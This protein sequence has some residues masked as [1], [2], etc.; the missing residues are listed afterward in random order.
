MVTAAPLWTVSRG[1]ATV[2]GVAPRGEAPNGRRR[3]RIIVPQL[4]MTVTVNTIEALVMAESA[5]PSSAY[6]S[7]TTKT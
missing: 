1:S 3:T 6:C 4:A 5:E 7:Q 2:R